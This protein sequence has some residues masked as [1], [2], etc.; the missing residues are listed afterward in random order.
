MENL[1]GF[2]SAQNIINMHPILGL[3]RLVKG[4]PW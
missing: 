1:N 2:L 4:W 3:A